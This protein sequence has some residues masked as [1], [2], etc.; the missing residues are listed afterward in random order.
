MPSFNRVIFAGHLGHDPSLKTFDNG[1][2]VCEMDVAS[3]EK[4][5][6]KE[7]NKQESVEWQTVKVYGKQ[8]DNC[9]KYLAKGSAVLVEGK[10]KTRSWEKDG[11]KHYKTEI[12][13]NKF[14]GVQFLGSPKDK[15]EQPAA[16]PADNMSV[17]L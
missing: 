15:T 4:W 7:G 1:D 5:T 8:A 3:T 6:D 11:A 12:I 2:S 10:L 14:G 16:A 9:K 13:A 17:D